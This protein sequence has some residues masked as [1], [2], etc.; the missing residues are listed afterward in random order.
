[1]VGITK[2]PII[3]NS[4]GYALELAA[5]LSSGGEIGLGPSD[6]ALCA[7]ALRLY[8]YAERRDSVMKFMRIPTMIATAVIGL[9]AMGGSH[10]VNQA[11]GE[12]AVKELNTAITFD[13]AVSGFGVP[14]AHS[15]AESLA[16]Q[17][18]AAA[19]VPDDS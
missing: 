1:M 3:V 7:E 14:V 10:V 8:A 9:M 4:R 19:F 16:A 2:E 11:N 17:S 13:K 15:S 18:L 5:Q 12:A 6:S